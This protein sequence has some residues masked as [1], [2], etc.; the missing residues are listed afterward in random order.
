MCSTFGKRYPNTISGV[1]RI[2]LAI[3]LATSVAASLVIYNQQ[4]TTINNLSSELLAKSQEVDRMQQTIDEYS[5]LLESQQEE[6]ADKSVQLEALETEVDSLSQE[7]DSQRTL[8]TEQS[9][10]V[11]SLEQEISALESEMQAKDRDL[12]KIMLTNESTKRVHVAHYGLG[13][14]ENDNGIVFPIEVELIRSGNGRI[15]VNVS[16]VQFEATFQDAVRTAAAVASKYTG[17]TVSDKDIIVTLVNNSDGLIS[18][19]GPSAGAV[20]AAMIAAGLEEK[21]LD[22]SVLVTGAIKSDGTIARVGGISGKADAAAAFGAKT[23]LVPEGQA[24]Q[25]TKIT[26]VGVSNIKELADRII[27]D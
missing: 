15:S 18:V 24:F 26:V 2:A 12:A 25:S 14:D 19:D 21:Q 27:A 22:S 13:V 20:L 23:L 6:L 17:V 4:T 10:Q 5:S 11:T 7:I 1:T 16:D 9:T 8:I 3:G